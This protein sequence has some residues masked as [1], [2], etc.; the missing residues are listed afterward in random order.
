MKKFDIAENEKPTSS[1]RRLTDKADD[2][3]TSL[4]DF[5]IPARLQKRPRFGDLVSFDDSAVASTVEASSSSAPRPLPPAV[6]ATPKSSRRNEVVE[7]IRTVISK[8]NEFRESVRPTID[9]LCL[10][11]ELGSD[12]DA[13]DLLQRG[14]RLDSSARA[15]GV[16]LE[17]FESR[18]MP[19]TI[20][21][22]VKQHLLP[23]NVGLEH[24]VASLMVPENAEL[25]YYLAEMN[26]VRDALA[27]LD[28]ETRRRYRYTYSYNMMLWLLKSALEQMAFHRFNSALR[29]EWLTDGE[30]LVLV[31]QGDIMKWASDEQLLA[32]RKN[33]AGAGTGAADY[34]PYTIVGHLRPLFAWH[35]SPPTSVEAMHAFGAEL[36]AL[37]NS[38]RSQNTQS[39]KSLRSI[40][41]VESLMLEFTLAA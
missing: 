4:D 38:M 8:R 10:Y 33:A 40:F 25:S 27:E 3:S 36:D 13:V 12:A 14:A 30:F 21:Y 22:L 6:P 9:N 32:L 24:F 11:I 15:L 2:D 37:F 28:N 31:R 41:R 23:S 35:R 1:L 5:K 19:L 39:A 17:L 16:L 34:N 26:A 20:T 18:D 7:R 29:T